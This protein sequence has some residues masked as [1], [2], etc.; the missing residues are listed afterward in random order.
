MQKEVE[1]VA[2]RKSRE[3]RKDPAR[4]ST[5]RVPLPRIALLL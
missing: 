1:D 3:G 2:R 4:D 5:S